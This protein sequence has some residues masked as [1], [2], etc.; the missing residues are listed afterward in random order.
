MEKTRLSSKGQVI[1]P[2]S[3]RDARGWKE[4]EE[5]LVEETKDGVMLRPAQPFPRTTLQEVVGC[6]KYEGP[7]R[8]LEEMDAAVARGARERK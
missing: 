2:K 1:I 3:I 5:L 4:G 7:R 6:M 8:S